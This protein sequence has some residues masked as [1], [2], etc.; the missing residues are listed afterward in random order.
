MLPDVLLER[1]Q[2]PVCGG[3]PLVLGVEEDSG[4]EVVEGNL[5][6][7]DCGRWYPVYDDIARIMPPD[8]ASNLSASD[9]RW[10]EWAATMHRFI[11]WR[12]RAW[13]DPEKAAERRETALRM[14]RRFIEFCALSDDARVLLDIGAGTGHVADLLPAAM[15]YI[16]VDPLP[17]GL[18]PAG[19][20]PEAMPRPEREVTFLQCVGE[21]LPFSDQTFDV[22]IMMGALD[23]ARSPREVLEQAARVLKP[24]ATLGL[25]QGLTTSNSGG[26]AGVFGSTLHALGGAGGADATETH[27]HAFAS[28]DAVL[29]LIA[30]YFEVLDTKEDSGRAF[31]RAQN[32]GAGQ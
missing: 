7:P 26:L 14:H 13:G 5:G 29:E 19:D 24:G 20:I 27:L 6:C 12:R 2:C 31:V 10:Q 28:T 17:G 9:E 4:E 21:H 3:S 18:A 16:G 30:D 1:L 11:S 23:H 25:L 15:T 22:A 8:L 32:P